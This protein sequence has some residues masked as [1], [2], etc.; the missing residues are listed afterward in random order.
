VDAAGIQRKSLAFGFWQLAKPFVSWLPQG[1]KNIFGSEDYKA[2]G[3]MRKIF[4]KVVNEDLRKW[5]S[6]ILCPVT[7]VWGENDKVLPIKQGKQM[8]EEI[9]NSKFRV[10]W[11]GDHWPHIKKFDDFMLVLREEGIMLS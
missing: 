7:I 4:V 2:A 3:E 8:S 6:K 10:V 9:K 1:I 5:F 11:G